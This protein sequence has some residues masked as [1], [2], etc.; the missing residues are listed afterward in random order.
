MDENKE[1][2]NK[3]GVWWEPAV[4]IFTQV[5]GWIAGPIILAM[6]VGKVLDNHYNTKP[7]LF[8]G[9][10]GLAFIISSYGIVKAVT[11][12]MKKFSSE[13]EDKNELKQ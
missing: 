1:K 9:F 10:S 3:D 11:K 7:W 8:I 4:E 13:T 5:S 2:I 6:I 12:Y